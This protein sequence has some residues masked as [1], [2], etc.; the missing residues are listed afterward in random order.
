MS[1]NR[2]EYDVI[3]AG[4]GPAGLSTAIEL[5]KNLNINTL[6]IEKNKIGE[7]SHCWSVMKNH[8]EVFNLQNSINYEC[9]HFTYSFGNNSR[10]VRSNLSIVDDKKLLSHLKKRINK[11]NCKIKEDTKFLNYCYLSKDREKLLINTSQGQ[12]VSKLLIDASGWNSP[13]V[14]KFNLRN[15]KIYI[16]NLV[17]IYNEEKFNKSKIDL[18][19]Y[20]FPTGSNLAGFWSGPFEKGKDFIGIFYLVK[21]DLSSNY[22]EQN[23][24]KFE[25][26]CSFKTQPIKQ[27]K[28]NIPL[29][30]NQKNNINNILLVGDSASHPNT[31]SGFGLYR[32]LNN[33]KIAGL[34]AA[35]SIN[36]KNYS[37]KLNEKFKNKINKC[38]R[39]DYS[40]GRL[41]RKIM[42]YSNYDQMGQYLK[43]VNRLPNDLLN[44]PL[45]GNATYREIQIA[46]LKI[47]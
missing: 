39:L 14:E 16:Q 9:D 8:L 22:I 25:Q 37:Q 13:I 24:K 32:A 41:P 29:F 19:K 7:K 47:F 6:L 44:K 30:C 21:K 18:L 3:I 28:G 45:S 15:N 33:G 46:I 27:I 40:S 38:Y 20:P 2:N 35:N 12:Y 17:W 5:S 1:G 10:K 11:N 23:L 43:S 26:Y 4:G 34:F 36:K 42:Y 31:V